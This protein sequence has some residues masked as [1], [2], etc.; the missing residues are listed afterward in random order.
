MSKI[1]NLNIRRLDGGLLLVF[2]S[3]MRQRQTVLAAQEL[4][5]SQSAISHALGRL[6]DLLGD[7]LFTRRPNGLEPTRRARELLP[8]V[9]ELLQ[10][11]RALIG[12]PADFT[13][14]TSDRQFRIAAADLVTTLLAGTLLRQFAGAAPL[15]RLGFRFLVG[16]A[17][18]E[19]LA[20]DEV[21]LAVGR[22]HAV[23]RGFA[24]ET[25]FEENYVVIARA[26][27]PRVAAGLDLATY[28]ELDHLLVSFSGNLTGP[29]D[30][31]LQRLGQRRRVVAGLP[32]F[33]SV[34]DAV[35]Q[36][37]ALAT[38]SSRLARRHAGNFGLRILPVPFDI[39]PFPVVTLFT[40]P[41]AA[42]PATLWLRE[43]IRL[44][45]PQD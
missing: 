30:Q 44:A 26:G 7:P 29:A 10:R 16:R 14:A 1:D 15:A 24:A 19:A 20:R 40:E 11:A 22:F 8:Q 21:D 36:S 6:R 5:L 17:A 38:V 25:L 4:G 39:V 32:L 28:L 2:R 9:E 27:H 34:F 37:D 41:R 42:E 33:M 13:P 3:L 31:A 45:L 18:L 12:G 23:P 43:Q 35:A